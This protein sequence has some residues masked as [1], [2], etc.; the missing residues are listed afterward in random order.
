LTD[1]SED[2]SEPPVGIERLYRNLPQ[3]VGGRLI[4]QG[5]VDVPN[6]IIDSAEGGIRL[7][8]IESKAELDSLVAQLTKASEAAAEDLFEEYER[9]QRDDGGPPL[10]VEPR[11]RDG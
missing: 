2:V 5:V 3:G 4:A 1:E 8:T 6:E 11:A 7:P 10:T 9:V